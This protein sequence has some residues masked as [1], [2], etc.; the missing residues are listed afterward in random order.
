MTKPLFN[1]TGYINKSSQLAFNELLT[2]AQVLQQLTVQTHNL[3]GQ[4][5]LRTVKACVFHF[6]VAPC[7]FRDIFSQETI[8]H[9]QTDEHTDTN[10]NRG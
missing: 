2:I 6:Y 5:H 9:T 8:I 1:C 7:A 3:V 4:S 10:K